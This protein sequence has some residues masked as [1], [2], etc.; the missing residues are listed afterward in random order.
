MPGTNLFSISHFKE[1]CR[2]QAG[3]W[4][5]KPRIVLNIESTKTI[6]L[7]RARDI[8]VKQPRIQDSSFSSR[9]PLM[10]SPSVRMDEMAT[11]LVSSQRS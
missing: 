7:S 2:L 3:G 5:E 11:A 6:Y 1:T 8:Q 9:I 4:K 10:L